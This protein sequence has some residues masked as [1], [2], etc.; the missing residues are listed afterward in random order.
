VKASSSAPSA[1]DASKS[2][3]NSHSPFVFFL[4]IVMI[5]YSCDVWYVD[6]LGLCLGWTV[7]DG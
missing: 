7:G 1:P 2:M 6:C 5:I 4:F 3:V